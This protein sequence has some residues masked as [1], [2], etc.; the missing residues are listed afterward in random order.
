MFRDETLYNNCTRT[1]AAK[2]LRK[3]QCQGL[4]KRQSLHLTN[5][6]LDSD[7]SSQLMSYKYAPYL[8]KRLND[9]AQLMINQVRQISS[10]GRREVTITASSKCC[11]EICWHAYT[12]PFRRYICKYISSYSPFRQADKGAPMVGKA[13]AISFRDVCIILPCFQCFD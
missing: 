1:Q 7:S 3:R 2:S 6:A 4:R 8:T 11:L 9:S 5:P 10:G 12:R 13:S